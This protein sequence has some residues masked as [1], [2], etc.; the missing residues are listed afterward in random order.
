MEIIT[1]ISENKYKLSLGNANE[2]SLDAVLDTA[3]NVEEFDIWLEIKSDNEVQRLKT[4]FEKLGG[5]VKKLTWSNWSQHEL[6]AAEIIGLLGSL[7][8]LESLKLS[9]W[10]KPFTG[11]AGSLDLPNISEI[12]VSEGNNF[13]FDFLTAALPEN[14][15]KSLR[16][17]RISEVEE[18]LVQFLKKQSSITRLDVQGDISNVEALSSLK[19]ERL[20]V[21]LYEKSEETDDQK[22][23]LQTLIKS[24]SELVDLDLLNDSDYSF[25][26]VDDAIFA[27]I[28]ALSKL[29]NLAIA[30]DGLTA[31]GIKEIT[32]LT[33]LKNLRVKTNRDSSLELFKELGEL[34][35][36]SL[37]SLVLNLWSFDIPADTYTAFGQN[38]ENLKALRITLGTRHSIEF[39]AKAFPNLEDLSVRFGEANNRVEFSQAFTG[40]ETVDSKLKKLRLQF[41]GGETI[42]TDKFLEF[43]GLFANLEKLDIHTKFP[44]SAAFIN[45][46]A[47]KLG[48]IKSI[49]L[50]SF[51]VRNSETF[52][53]E[54]VD[55]L[56]ALREKVSYASLSLANVQHVDFGGGIPDDADGESR[57]FTF[58]PLVDA[59]KGV[60]EP[61][62]S[63]LANIRIHN[64]LELIA[65]K[66]E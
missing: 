42:D 4:L 6:S 61:K 20:R 27:D 25:C 2:D 56:K 44:F 66:E 36:S 5:S 62:S 49:K 45:Q 1:E 34:K 10:Q 21:I 64:N 38:F 8:S 43:L 3:S 12:E 23:F 19:L 35:L 32:N 17:D 51:E 60:Y 31:N 28:A 63:S 41:W 24:Q 65:G 30:I 9:S 11:D 52:P 47:D 15:I 57:Q 40:G 48:S 26:F 22:K 33:A 13:I 50:S 46:L 14:T 54:T 16:V 53:T 18:K 29:E 55:A 7:K 59:L 37:E 39:F 58:Q